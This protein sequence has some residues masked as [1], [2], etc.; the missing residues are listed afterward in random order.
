MVVSQLVNKMASTEEKLLQCVSLILEKHPTAVNLRDPLYGTSLIQVG[1]GSRLSAD[2][3]HS[4]V[5]CPFGLTSPAH[6]TN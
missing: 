3:I 5:T 1:E 6:E 2:L 4:F